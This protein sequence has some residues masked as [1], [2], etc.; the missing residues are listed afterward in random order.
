M[1][2]CFN[3]SIRSHPRDT[4][5]APWL[6]HSLVV[7]GVHDLRAPIEL[8]SQ[9][10]RRESDLVVGLTVG[11]WLHPG[12]VVNGTRWQVTYQGS[13]EP[14][15]DQLMSATYS[16]HWNT[17]SHGELKQLPFVDISVQR[18]LSAVIQLLKGSGPFAHRKLLADVLTAGEDKGI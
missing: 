14:R 4:H 16:E 8:L 7:P 10:S 5:P 11:H 1:F 12:K 17:P 13:A 9:G 18:W 15:I 6:S 2:R 3:D